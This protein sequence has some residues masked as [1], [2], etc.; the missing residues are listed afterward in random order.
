MCELYS[1]AVLDS[2]APRPMRRT[3]GS[4]P[5]LAVGATRK[6]KSGQL[7]MKLEKSG[8]GRGVELGV[9]VGAF[10]IVDKVAA[11]LKALIPS[12]AGRRP[13]RPC[14]SQSSL[15]SVPAACGSHPMVGGPP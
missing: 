8:D 2:S 6:E 11:G 3:A 12:E 5:L 1:L 9:Q 7:E 14:D 10:L 4:S 13:L 15:A